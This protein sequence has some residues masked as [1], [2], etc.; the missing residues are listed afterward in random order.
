MPKSYIKGRRIEYKA[1]EELKKKYKC[2]LAWRSAGSHSFCDVFG[3]SREKA[4]FIQIKTNKLLRKDIEKMK[5]LAEKAP[6]NVVFG[7]WL[8]EDKKGFTKKIMFKK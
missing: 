5:E 2:F 6:E 3:V 8:W 7:I 1:I 4:Y